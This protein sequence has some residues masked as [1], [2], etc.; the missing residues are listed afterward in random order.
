[1]RIV[2]EF[3]PTYPLKIPILF[4][5]YNRI[6]T[7]REVFSVLRKVKPPKLYIASDGP[8]KD[9]IEDRRKVQTVRDFI[10]RHIDWNCE[11]RTLFRDQNFGCRLA[12]SSAITWFFE[13][14]EMGIILEDDTLPS[15]SFFWFC[16]ELLE[17]YRNE[18]RV[19][20]IGGNNFQRGILRGDG[21]YY[22]SIFNHIWGWASWSDRWKYYDLNLSNIKDS[23]FID[24]YFYPNKSAIHFFKKVF[25]RIKNGKITSTWDYQYTF[26]IW[27]YGGLSIVPN[28]NLVK[29]IGFG[30]DAV[31]AHDRNDPLANLPIYEM[32]LERHPSGIVRIHEADELTYE[33]AYKPRPLAV[34]IKNKLKRFLKI[35]K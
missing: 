30:I 15:I 19:W 7:T 9:D 4:L 2:E 22:F 11:V 1:M 5:T 25:E 29:N 12:V 31:H 18:H 32:I 21:D 23:S 13:N 6:Q 24:R 34:R 35:F 8:K 33:I 28:I 3:I 14:E 17:K 26:T 27:Y 20:H 16:Q 10:L